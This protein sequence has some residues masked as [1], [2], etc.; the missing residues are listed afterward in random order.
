MSGPIN[1]SSHLDHDP[2]FEAETGMKGGTDHFVSKHPDPTA[3]RAPDPNNPHDVRFSRA[4]ENMDASDSTPLNHADS[5]YM[6][7]IKKRH[8]GLRQRLREED[9]DAA[10]RLEDREAQ[11][12]VRASGR[13]ARRP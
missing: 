10:D 2:D 12:P 4:V 11:R 8:A 6:E 5:P 9:P 1:T 13:F 7:G 3:D